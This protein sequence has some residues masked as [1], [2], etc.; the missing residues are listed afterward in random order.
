MKKNDLPFQKAYD[1]FKNLKLSEATKKKMEAAMSKFL[2]TIMKAV[3]KEAESWAKKK[4]DEI[5][6]KYE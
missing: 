1:Y 6:K 4:I 3:A 2:E 5:K